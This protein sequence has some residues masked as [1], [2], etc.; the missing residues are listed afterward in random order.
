MFQFLYQKW[1]KK[2]AHISTIP[3][4]KILWENFAKIPL[5]IPYLIRVPAPKKVKKEPQF[6]VPFSHPPRRH[7]NRTKN[8]PKNWPLFNLNFFQF[9]AIF[10][11]K[12]YALLG[13]IHP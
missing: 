7:K 4:P 3:N 1:V 11:L 13:Y 9:R 10:T 6:L 2:Q 5:D 8:H 12:N